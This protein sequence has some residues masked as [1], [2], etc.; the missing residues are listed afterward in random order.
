[1]P[2]TCGTA[3]SF[4]PT[5]VAAYKPR[6]L[7][8]GKPTAQGAGGRISG[9]ALP[10]KLHLATDQIGG[11]KHWYAAGHPNAAYHAGPF[12][13]KLPKK[14][15]L[16]IALGDAVADQSLPAGPRSGITKGPKPN[17]C[18]EICRSHCG[19]SHFWPPRVRQITE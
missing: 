19:Q 10:T 14:P 18:G 8:V 11:A 12:H 15:A 2:S 4:S 7:A 5:T 6:P 3:S 17:A 13:R 16:I 9:W 1:M